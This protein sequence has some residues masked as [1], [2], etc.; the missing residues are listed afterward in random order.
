VYSRLQN[1]ESGPCIEGGNRPRDEV[2]VG[3]PGIIVEEEQD[4]ATSLVGT[5]ITAAAGTEI[6]GQVEGPDAV[7]QVY[8]FPPVTDTHDVEIDIVLSEE[9]VQATL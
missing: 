3:Q 9:G 4:L 1:A 6:L 2:G 5:R 7:R 8:W